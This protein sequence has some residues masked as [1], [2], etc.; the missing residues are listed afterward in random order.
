LFTVEHSQKTLH[1]DSLGIVRR[2]GQP[3]RNAMT[4]LTAEQAVAMLK[5]L[6]GVTVL[7][8][9][10]SY[11]ACGNCGKGFVRN[12]V[13]G[14]C[15]V[16]VEQRRDGKWMLAG[17]PFDDPEWAG[18]KFPTPE[19]AMSAVDAILAT[20]PNVLALGIAPQGDAP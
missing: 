8:E 15:F 2:A 18:D 17:W 7:G 13:N 3:E 14:T 19:L 12:S 10:K 4:Q 20:A 1:E 9:W 6:E 5:Q 11:H 16:S